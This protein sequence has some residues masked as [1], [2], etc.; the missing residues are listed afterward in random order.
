MGVYCALLHFPPPAPVV[1]VT[2]GYEY[3]NTKPLRGRLGGE[4]VRGGE[5][6]ASSSLSVCFLVLALTHW[7]LLAV[8]HQL[9]AVIG[10]VE[11]H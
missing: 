10:F 2:S 8:S 5:K 11:V 7:S 9:S 6:D 3:T 1:H 4:K